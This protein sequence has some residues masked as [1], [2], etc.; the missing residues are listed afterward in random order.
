[1][2]HTFSKI[3]VSYYINCNDAINNINRQ[4][5]EFP[6]T[7]HIDYGRSGIIDEESVVYSLLEENHIMD[8]DNIKN[9]IIM[10][11]EPTK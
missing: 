1:M 9:I 10:Y 7:K 3:T 6:I 8:E 4:I 5:K 2:T 11:V